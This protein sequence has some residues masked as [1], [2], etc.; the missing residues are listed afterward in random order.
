M[1]LPKGQDLRMKCMHDAARPE[2]LNLG[3][4]VILVQIIL[5]CVT[6]QSFG[7]HKIPMKIRFT[8]NLIIYHDIWC[9]PPCFLHWEGKTM[10][11]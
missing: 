10:I 11:H 9:F 7:F 8:S 5:C 4:V 6:A 3:T 1:C 2:V